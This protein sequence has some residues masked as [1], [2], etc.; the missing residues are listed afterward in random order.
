MSC[1]C[2]GC[3]SIWLRRFLT[4]VYIFQHRA[5]VHTGFCP[6]REVLDKQSPNRVTH[7]TTA[8]CLCTIAGV[9]YR[10][11]L[12]NT[13]NWTVN[14]SCSGNTAAERAT[15]RSTW[16]PSPYHLHPTGIWE[17]WIIGISNTAYLWKLYTSPQVHRETGLG[18][19]WVLFYWTRDHWEVGKGYWWWKR[20][21]DMYIGKYGWGL[22]NLGISKWNAEKRWLSKKDLINIYLPFL[23]E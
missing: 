3:A 9:P 8:P 23:V 10:P 15:P 1:H 14:R 22:V 21:Y 7:Y 16:T 19:D 11:T 18:V 13:L 17:G 6:M 2:Y 12:S 5:E 4:G 20:G